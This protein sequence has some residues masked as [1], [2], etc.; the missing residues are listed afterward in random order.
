MIIEFD[1]DT[2]FYP[3]TEDHL[4]LA[5]IEIG[6][7]CSTYLPVDMIKWISIATTGNPDNRDN[8][9]GFLLL[10]HFI[11][12]VPQILLIQ[13]KNAIEAEKAWLVSSHVWYLFPS[14]QLPGF[15]ACWLSSNRGRPGAA[16]CYQAFNQEEAALAVAAQPVNEEAPLIA[17]KAGLPLDLTT[18]LLEGIVFTKALSRVITP[19]VSPPPM[20]SASLWSVF[21]KAGSTGWM[22]KL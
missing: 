1:Y 3:G 11:F 21:M 7:P 18:Q 17:H 5:F 4:S 22:K 10:L 2:M 14:G 15:T 9:Q 16:N 8:S 20:P 13:P 19:K 6:L 12:E